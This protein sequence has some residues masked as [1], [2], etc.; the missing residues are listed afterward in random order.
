MDL[1]RKTS[2]FIIFFENKRCATILKQI[3]FFPQNMKYKLYGHPVSPFSCLA[4]ISL[5]YKEVEHEFIYVDLGSGEQKKTEYLQL[6]PF[7]Q[8][9]LL[10]RDDGLCIYESWAIFE[11]LEEQFTKH[12]MLSQKEPQRSKARSIALCIIT[13]IIPAARELFL[14]GLGRLALTDEQKGKANANLKDKL[15]ILAKEIESQDQ[16]PDL[17]PYDALFYQA[18]L[19]INIGCPGLS[20]AFPGLEKYWQSLAS[21]PAF[22][23]LESEPAVK[24]VRESFE[25]MLVNQK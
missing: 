10:M 20:S 1:P 14:N 24:K 23:K 21:K 5:L 18:W 6:H 9:P 16:Q 17:T 2:G 3:T 15:T 22:Q 8:V 12:P 11:H 7:G 13:S 25:S 19:N 4:F